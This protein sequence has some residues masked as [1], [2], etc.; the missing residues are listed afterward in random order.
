MRRRRI[1]TTKA[2][3][4]AVYPEQSDK[5]KARARFYKNH[6]SLT[7]HVTH[8]PMSSREWRQAAAGA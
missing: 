2:A 7:G 3:R 4:G 8:G 5:Q 1:N 6:T